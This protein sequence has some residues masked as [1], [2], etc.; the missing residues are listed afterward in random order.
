MDVVQ[1]PMTTTTFVA[2][3]STYTASASGQALGPAS[4]VNIA[5]D[6]PAGGA[7]LP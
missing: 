3:V 2:D 6:Q 1:T 7:A 5:D 4:T